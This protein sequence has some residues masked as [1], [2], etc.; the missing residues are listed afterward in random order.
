MEGAS[1]YNVSYIA[2]AMEGARASYCNVSYI[3]IANYGRS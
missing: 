1:Y 3:A 2:I